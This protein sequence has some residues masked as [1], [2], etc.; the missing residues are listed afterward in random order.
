MLI[1]SLTQENKTKEVTIP[2]DWEDITLE[3]WCGIYKI[4]M[5]HKK[6]VDLRNKAIKEE[7]GIEEGENKEKIDFT[8][9]MS[10][11]GMEKMDILKMNKD[12][13]QYVADMTDEEM[14]YVN[15]EEAYEVLAA[16]NILTEDYKPTGARSF[17]FEDEEYFFPSEYLKDNTFGD[18]IEATQ[19]DLYIDS[20]TSGRFDVL[21]EQMA[22]LCR[23]IDEVYDDSKIPEKAEA[24]RKLKMDTVWEFSF[25]L[26]H[27]CEKL[28]SLLQTYLEEKEGAEELLEVK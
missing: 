22:I 10:L 5:S 24:F 25:F 26:T 28:A 13:F 17:M 21:P 20:M 19:L 6:K 3:Y 14:E 16:L 4:V 23:K 27:R 18:Y 12:L 15:L 11:E 8:T 2:T 1:I 9:N 7:K